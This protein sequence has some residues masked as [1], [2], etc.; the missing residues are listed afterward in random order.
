LEEYFILPRNAWTVAK[1]SNVSDTWLAEK[2]SASDISYLRDVAV[3]VAVEHSIDL[4]EL[5]CGWK[6]HVEKIERDIPLDSSDRTVWGAHD[7]VAAVSLRTFLEEGLADL[8]PEIRQRVERIVGEVDERFLSYTEVDELGLL[9][10]LSGRSSP[11]RGW[12]WRRI[13]KAGP[14]REE[15]DL[16][17]GLGAR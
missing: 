4:S 7:V 12:W 10:R 1:M 17:S 15:I 9:E 8:E 6:G 11:S 3:Y 13:P 2:L 5:L 14:A 16:F